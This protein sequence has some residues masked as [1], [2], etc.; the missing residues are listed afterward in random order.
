MSTPRRFHPTGWDALEERVVLSAIGLRD[1][2]QRPA[3]RSWHQAAAA[4]RPDPSQ[5]MQLFQ[6][7]RLLLAQAQQRALLAQQQPRRAF[8]AP[9]ARLPQSP[10]VVIDQQYAAFAAD[11]AAAAAGYLESLQVQP[12]PATE[13][14]LTLSEFYI[15]RSGVFVVNE[16]NL[17]PASPDAPLR[18]VVQ[19]PGNS[20]RLYQVT[21][22]GAGIL[23]GVAPYNPLTGEFGGDLG[24]EIVQNEDGVFNQVVIPIPEDPLPV[25]TSLNVEAPEVTV[26]PP[27]TADIANQYLGFVNQR[28][29]QLS[30]DLVTYFNRLPIRLPR[31]PGAY[32]TPRPETAIQFFLTSQIAGQEPQ[33][34]LS[35]LL[36]QPLPS[37]TGDAVDFYNASISTIIEN[38]RQQVRE[39]VRLLFAGKGL[40][41]ILPVYP[42]QT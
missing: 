23:T 2:L 13:T 21:G 6:Q 18:V 40:G 37:S 4:N 22:T 3:L 19:A 17:P 16:T 41:D 11:I 34:L 26:P 35:Q 31:L 27:N 36:A 1:P 39:S 30:G 25:G 8:Q 5:R 24:T 33:I 12:P 7:Q 32:Y 38:S 42:G 20:P 9:S 15:P 14:Q 29:L 28:T 10:E